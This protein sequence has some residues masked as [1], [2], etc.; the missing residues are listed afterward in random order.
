VALIKQ[1]GNW[2]IW[3]NLGTPLTFGEIWGKFGKFGD[4]LDFFNLISYPRRHQIEGN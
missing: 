1:T 3:G 2:E 4:A